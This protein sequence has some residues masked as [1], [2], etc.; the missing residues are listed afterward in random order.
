MPY[1]VAHGNQIETIGRVE[2]AGSDAQGEARREALQGRGEEADAKGLG[3]QV[4][5]LPSI[6]V[7]GFPPGSFLGQLAEDDLAA[8]LAAGRPATHRPGELILHEGGAPS[9]VLAVLGGTV[10][11]T[12]VSTAGR[13]VVLELRGGGEIVGELGAID[14]EPRSASV[15]A[16]DAVE[17]QAIPAAAFAALVRSS[18]GLS[19]VLIATLVQ[20]LRASAGRQLEL[21][22]TDSLGRVCQRLAELA[23]SHGETTPDGVLVLRAISQQELADWCGISR[24]G[25]V[26]ALTELRR[27]GW[28]ET[29]R[30]RLLLR[31]L[32]MLRE[33]AGTAAGK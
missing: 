1:R 17:V 5:R 14:G 31:D 26:R 2:E 30:Q 9:V 22:S 11:L 13:E 23:E 18:S 6:G 27:L 16:L 33:R 20:R 25:V 7:S 8:L 12:K 32:D 21:G 28:V 19:T 3:D 15:V 29:G 24:D 10:K 4:A